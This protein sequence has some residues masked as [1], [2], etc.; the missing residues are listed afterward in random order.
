MTN[1]MVNQIAAMLKV[2]SAA[3]EHNRAANET[4]RAR[5]AFYAACHRWKDDNG[6][7]RYEKL[8]A[9][10]E[11]ASDEMYAAVNNELTRMRNAK[12]AEYNAKRRLQTAI[13]RAEAI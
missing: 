5:E 9:I 10:D 2:A 3:I 6:F 13:R 11:S 8:I 1:A 12:R 7:D 4:K